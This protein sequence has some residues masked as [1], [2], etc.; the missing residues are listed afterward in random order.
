MRVRRLLYKLI[1]SQALYR[2]Y[3]SKTLDEL[4]GQD[5][6]VNAL[7]ASIKNGKISHAYLLTG[8]RGTGKTSVARI[9]AHDINGI[10]YDESTTNL[11]I[12]EIDA[13]SNRRIDEI[14]DLRE[15]VHIAP[16]TLK[17][18][19]YIIDEVHM[20]TKEAFNALLKTLEE[21]PEHAIF[22]LATT[23]LSKV[24]DTIISRTQRYS[25]KPI[26]LS[27]LVSHLSHIAKQE[28]ITADNEALNLIAEHAEGGFRDAIGLLDQVRHTND[29]VTV[30]S[31]MEALGSPPHKSLDELWHALIT[32]GTTTGAQL[33]KLYEAGYHAP[34]IA[35]SL[36]GRA[37]GAG[38]VDLARKLLGVQSSF[39]PKTELLLITL[40]LKSTAP[41]TPDTSETHQEIPQKPKAEKKG[42]IQKEKPIVEKIAP[43]VL[44]AP[45]EQ[46]QH[47]DVWEA[48]LEKVKAGGHSV[49]GPLRLAEATVESGIVNLGLAFPF[50]IKRINEPKNLE[51]L[52]TATKEVT[53]QDHQIIVGRIQRSEITEKPTRSL[54]I[55]PIVDD[56]DVALMSDPLSIVKNVFGDA[57]I[58]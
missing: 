23:E 24:P 29:S 46:P 45:K 3:R 5:H 38:N 40:E 4:V 9:L 26:E 42:P 12:I 13:A 51:V 49:Y 16:S 21:P 18:K 36:L 33:Q 20:L 52:H 53:G 58:L 39:D 15:K 7:R 6:I 44:L 2:K 41:N 28:S 27:K 43:G 30:E 17:Y 54:P 48:I 31:V 47:S 8:P 10:Q 32:Q 25:F 14:R 37:V 56:P 35:K 34:Q 22:I 19:I 57:Q 1:M 55:E 50:H 11:D